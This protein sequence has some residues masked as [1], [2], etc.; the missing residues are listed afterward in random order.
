MCFLVFLTVV[1][2]NTPYLQSEDVC[3]QNRRVSGLLNP[4][5]LLEGSD[6]MM[7]VDLGLGL[8]NQV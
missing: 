5:G 2:K 3:G 6:L 4:K 8:S 7:R 1:L